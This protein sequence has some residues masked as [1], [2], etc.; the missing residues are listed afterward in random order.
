MVEAGFRATADLKVTQ[1]DFRTI[2]FS[3]AEHLNIS[4]AL[5]V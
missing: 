2:G 3:P 5:P 1:G 4:L